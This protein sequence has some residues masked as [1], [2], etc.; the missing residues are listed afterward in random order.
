[1]GQPL[2]R[3][4]GADTR[5]DCL[6][7]HPRRYTDPDNG[8]STPVLEQAWRAVEAFLPCYSSV[9]RGS[10]FKSQL[11]TEAYERARAAVGRFVGSRAE[12]HANMLPWRRHDL[13]LL[14]FAHSADELCSACEQALR[15]E[16]IDLVAVTGASNVT[17]EVWPS[18]QL[19][20][21]AHAHGARFFIDAAQL[22]PHRP[23]DMAATGIDLLA[24]SGHKLYAPFGAGALVGDMGW[25]HGGAPLLQ[26]GG[27]VEL[28]S[29]DDVI[30][31]GTPERYE[32]GS[33]ERRGRGR[34][35]GGVRAP[36]RDRDAVRRRAR[37]R[38]RAAPVG[39]AR[40]GRRARDA[41]A[42]AA[43]ERRP[44]R[45]RDVQ[46]GGLP[47][48]PAGGRAQRGACHRGPPRMLLRAPADHPPARRGRARDRAAARGAARRRASVPARSGARASG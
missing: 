6:D 40:G 46:P 17:G 19:A 13:R 39:G 7:G 34:T 42:L 21:L 20:A 23:I 36:V 33:P 10:G 30:W 14:P 26:G 16:R 43:G 28:V 25:L 29:H 5:V 8:A 24:F 38:A 15:R 2:G 37:A 41:D 48:V 22:A 11:A 9:H 27:A 32:A 1:M 4:L 47:P 18:A 31:A 12:H 44:D 45:R 3:L 35:G